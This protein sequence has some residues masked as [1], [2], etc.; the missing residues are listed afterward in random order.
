MW[1]YSDVARDLDRDVAVK[2]SR[3]SVFST[4][5]IGYPIVRPTQYSYMPTFLCDVPLDILVFLGHPF[6]QEQSKFGLFVIPMDILWD[7]PIFLG[8]SH[9]MFQTNILYW[10]SI[11]I[12][13]GIS[14]L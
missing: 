9:R 8:T 12:S 4:Y 1:A 3:I 5:P 13:L 6:G 14:L 7:I 2:N 10:I 11:S